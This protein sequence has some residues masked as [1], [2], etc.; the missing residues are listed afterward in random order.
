[1]GRGAGAV[2]V[3]GVVAVG[4]AAGADAM[5][6]ALAFVFDGAWA[7]ENKHIQ[8]TMGKTSRRLAMITPDKSE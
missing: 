4:V 1:M 5:A 7:Q 6:A 8:Q 3:V 2:A